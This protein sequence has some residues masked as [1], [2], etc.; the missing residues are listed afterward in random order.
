[1][2]VPSSVSNLLALCAEFHADPTARPAWAV[3]RSAASYR[4]WLVRE[5]RQI[6]HQL[7]IQITSPDYDRAAAM[8]DAE[9]ASF[10]R[11]RRPT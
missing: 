5:L 2:T 4:S 3:G 6:R 10:D 1:M 11:R 8:I 9:L 7:D